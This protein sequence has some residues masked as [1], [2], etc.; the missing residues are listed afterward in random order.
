MQE[1]SFRSVTALV[2]DV[3]GTVVD[4]RA[5][6]IAEGEALGRAKGL[7][8]DWAAFADAWR[9]GYQPAMERVRR[10]ERPW[11]NLDA[12]HRE[13][14]DELLVE[15]RVG[16]LTEAEKDHLNR[17]WHRLAP[18]PDSVA[19]LGR[20]KGRFVVSTLTNGTFAGMI[21]MAKR[22]GLPWDGVLTAENV[23]HYKP[24]AEVYR[25]AIE[26]LGPEPER[27][28]M[29]AAHNYDLAH[30]RS[31]GMPTAFVPRPREHGPGQTTDIHPGQ[32]WDVVAADFL[33][34]ADKLGA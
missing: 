22:A 18:W 16:G 5:S 28:M 10:G 29:V 17:V 9:A 30:A 14:L 7:A 34:L 19:G 21:Q 11:A 13:R 15:F 32:A 12:L 3:F 25:M 20:L 4:W 2:F 6:V 23:R 33:D 24:D 31:H 26:L 1:A 27:V 8:V